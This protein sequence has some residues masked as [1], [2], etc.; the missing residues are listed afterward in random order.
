MLNNQK[1]LLNS[2]VGGSAAALP[3]Q[4]AFAAMMQALTQVTS[5]IGAVLFSGSEVE[6][7]QPAVQELSD[8]LRGHLLLPGSN[9]YDVARLYKKYQGNFDRPIEIQQKYDSGNLFRRSANIEAA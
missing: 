8:S 5:N 3:A 9:D 1:F 2:L 7:E 6:L 4:S